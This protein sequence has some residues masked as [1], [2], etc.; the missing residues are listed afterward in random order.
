MTYA[1]DKNYTQANGHN[2]KRFKVL[3]EDSDSIYLTE[4]EILQIYKLQP[5]KKSQI[6]IRDA[7]IIACYTGLRYSDLTQLGEDKFLD[8][9]TKIKIATIK[10]GEKVI[11]PLHWTIREILERRQGDFPRIYADQFFNRQIKLLAADA[12]IT[13]L[14]SKAITRGGKQV[15]KSYEK[16]KLVTIH[17]ARRSFATN[18]FKADM[19]VYSIMKITGH[20]SEKSFKKYIKIDSEQSAELIEDHIF[21]S[22]PGK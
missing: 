17:T 20:R 21:F 11:I 7:F 16:N 5:E 22:K 9:K 2:N 13:N 4:E 10:T 6:D 8:N 14:V 12:K 1:N 3:E 19:P 18:A 15:S